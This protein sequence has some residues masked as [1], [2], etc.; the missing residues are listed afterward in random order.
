MSADELEIDEAYAPISE[1]IQ[2]H[3]EAEIDGEEEEEDDKVKDYEAKYKRFN[4]EQRRENMR[5]LM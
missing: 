1:G 5:I 2:A 3:D 4:D